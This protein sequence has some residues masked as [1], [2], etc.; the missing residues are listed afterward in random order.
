[1][2]GYLTYALAAGGVIWAIA[3]FSAGVVDSDTAMMVVWA[4]L[5]VF[6]IRR[7]IN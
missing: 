4:S 6:G 1:M 5:A 3:G 7:A 2:K